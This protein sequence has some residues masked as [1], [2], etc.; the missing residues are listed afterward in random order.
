MDGRFL[1]KVGDLVKRKPPSDLAGR[2]GIIVSLDDSSEHVKCSER[3]VIAV[4]NR[5]R[6]YSY[7]AY[8]WEVVCES[9]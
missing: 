7:W 4:F 5:G 9:R 3:C 2:V 8:D 1:V 6:I